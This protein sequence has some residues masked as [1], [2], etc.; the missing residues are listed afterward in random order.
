MPRMKG[1]EGNRLGQEREKK[2]VEILS[3][4][5][6][7]D[8]ITS[9]YRGTQEDDANG[10]DVIVETIDAGKLFLQIKSSSTEVRKFKRK[11]EKRDIESTPSVAVVN[12]NENHKSEKVVWEHLRCLL[13][14]MRSD[15][16]NNKPKK[17]IYDL[18]TNERKPYIWSTLDDATNQQ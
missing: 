16:L 12:V 10:I 7:L 2:V 1:K 13:K 6:R 18:P 15:K 17:L 11:Y 3:R 8:W 4:E 14:R 9:V 5:D